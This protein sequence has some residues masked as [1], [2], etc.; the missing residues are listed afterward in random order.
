MGNTDTNELCN[1][2]NMKF[3]PS[4]IG[5]FDTPINKLII[6]NHPYYVIEEQPGDGTKYHHYF[7]ADKDSFVLVAINDR[8]K[9]ASLHNNKRFY[10]NDL[11]KIEAL[12]E[13][14]SV[15]QDVDIIKYYY[16]FNCN[17]FTLASAIRCM[18]YLLKEQKLWLH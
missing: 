10:F 12:I 17:M 11:L 8:I 6:S 18:I 1:G 3:D 14:T 2:G 16:S 4:I 9:G 5:V 15:Y 7:I 13:K